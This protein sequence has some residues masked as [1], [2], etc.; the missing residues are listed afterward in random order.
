MFDAKLYPKFSSAY[1]HLLRPLEHSRIR[2]LHLTWIGFGFGV[3]ASLLVMLGHYYTAILPL[4]L[5][6][7]FD[8]L[9]GALARVQKRMTA[10]GAFCDICLDFCFY[11]LFALS[12]AVSNPASR[13]LCVAFLLFSYV[14]SG[15][16]F[17]ALSGALSRTGKPKKIPA[18]QHKGL[19][20]V[21]GLCEGGETILSM[22]LMLLLFQYFCWIAWIFGALC[23]LTAL[24][25]IHMGARTLSR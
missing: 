21:A 4:L 17:L 8:G 12:F 7:I 5:N 22:L 9:D 1:E 15:S 10:I 20:F 3:V 18:Y 11:S 25:R 6:R 19:Y 24:L 23:V 16:S 2:P 14:L 13:A